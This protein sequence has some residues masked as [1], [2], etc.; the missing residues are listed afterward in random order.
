M[1]KLFYDSLF[2]IWR[3]HYTFTHST[4][5][6]WAASELFIMKY[7]DRLSRR[8]TMDANLVLPVMQKILVLHHEERS[9]VEEVLKEEIVVRVIRDWKQYLETGV[10]NKTK[11]NQ[12]EEL[13]RSFFQNHQDILS[14]LNIVQFKQ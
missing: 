13:E 5:T 11:G 6:A 7:Q 9:S 1:N 4:E 8:G 14:K 3:V 12:P 2:G 10:M